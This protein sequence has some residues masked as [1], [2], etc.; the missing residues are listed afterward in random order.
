[1]SAQATSHPYSAN[2]KEIIS[3]KPEAAPVTS[4]T[5]S[6]RSKMF[7]NEGSVMDT[8]IIPKQFDSTVI[9][10]EYGARNLANSCVAASCRDERCK[11]ACFALRNY[12][13]TPK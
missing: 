7:L 8:W 5:R 11:Q 3:P 9:Q 13:Y 1:M 6:V 4:A 2:A 10:L 12:R